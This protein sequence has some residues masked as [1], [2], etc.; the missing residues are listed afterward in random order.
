MYVGRTL[1]E[2][3]DLSYNKWTIEE[4]AYHQ[5][6]MTHLQACLNDRGQH[7]LAK[8]AAEIDA[9][10]GFPHYCGDYDGHGTTVHYD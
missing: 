1:E 5:T 6:T 7:V 4:L 2:L 10:G 8:I 3:Q 9:R